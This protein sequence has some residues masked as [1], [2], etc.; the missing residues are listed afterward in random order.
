MATAEHTA[1]VQAMLEAQNSG[2]PARWAALYAEDVTN[3]GRPS[4]R[5]GIRRIFE[6]LYTIFPDW[7][8]ELDDIVSDGSTVVAAMTMTG[9]HTGTSQVPVLGGALVGLPATNRPV[10]VSHIHWYRLNNG[11]VQDHRALRDDLGMM[12]QLGLVAGVAPEADISRPAR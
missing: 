12:Q 3:H 9:T 11:L 1:F 10:R 8:M 4:G 7:H 2:D 6:A 5:T